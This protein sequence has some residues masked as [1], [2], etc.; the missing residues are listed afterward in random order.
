MPQ[1]I[2]LLADI[3]SSHTE[4]WALA[5]AQKGYEIG[6]FSFNRTH[7][8]WHSTVKNIRVLNQAEFSPPKNSIFNKLKYL[9]LLPK[10]LEAIVQF[11]PDIL[12]A[13]YASSYG[14]L[15]A[16]SKFKPFVISA[17][18]SDVYEFPKKSFFQRSILRF[19]LKKADKILSTSYALKGELWKYTKKEIELIPFGV[20]I[21]KFSS[22]ATPF[23]KDPSIIHIGCIKAL[24]DIYGIKTL[25]EAVEIVKRCAPEKAIKLFLI[26][27][28]TR[29]NY[30]KKLTADLNLNDTVVFTG[31][32]PHSQIASYHNLMDILI[33]V[34]IANESFG[35]SVIESMA[36]EKAVIVSNAP[37]LME[38][39]DQY[40]LVVEKENVQQL[41]KAIIRLIHSSNLRTKLG[42]EARKHVIRN[43]DFKSCLSKQI[44]LY[45]TIVFKKEKQNLV[46]ISKKN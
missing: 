6:L 5:L 46:F 11:K 17:W 12:H 42:Q 24:E 43:Y 21:E 40:G 18:G 32:V 22:R 28:G 27:G 45:E 4:K 34:S 15:G 16:L 37:G 36:C 31:I 35:V 3:S 13:H 14:L 38:T 29:I 25:L 2:L 10:L 20:D 33:N 41:A 44:K 7:C 39:V 9:L 23:M 19:N 1:R 30:Y 26:G 8:D